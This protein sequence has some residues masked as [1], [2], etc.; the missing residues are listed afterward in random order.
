LGCFGILIGMDREIQEELERL[1]HGLTAVS[2][3]LQYD[4]AVLLGLFQYI[5]KYEAQMEEK[6]PRTVRKEWLGILNRIYEEQLDQIR[7]E[8]PNRASRLDLR[9][10]EPELFQL[11]ADE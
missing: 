6:D 8:D 5:V 11:P 2:A 10:L 7:A 4:R 1:K 3:Q 9:E